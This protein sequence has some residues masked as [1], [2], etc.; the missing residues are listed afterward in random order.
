MFHTEPK[1]TENETEAGIVLQ[2]NENQELGQEG[3]V[4]KQSNGSYYICGQT[5]KAVLYGMFRFLALVRQAQLSVLP[6]TEVPHNPI[7]MLNHWDNMDGSI[8]RGYSGNSFFFQNDEMM[9]DDRTRDYARFLAS[10]GINAVAINNVNVKGAATA[11]IS[12]RFY[13]QVQE[14]SELFLSFGVKLFLS[15]NYAMPCEYGLNTADPLDATVKEWW[16]NKCKEVYQNVPDLGGFL[17]KADSEGRPGPFTYG[18]TQAD[19]A[20][21]LAEAIRPYEGLIIWRCFVYNCQQDWRDYKTDRARAGYDY[22]SELDGNFAE[23]VVLQIKNGPMDFQVREPI[24]PLFGG[25]MKTNQMLEVQIA[26]EYTGQQRHICYLI[27]W[28]KEVLAFETYLKDRAKEQGVATNGKSTVADIVSGRTLSKVNCG[29]VAVTNTGNDENWTGHDMAAANLYGFGRLAFDTKLS[30]EEIAEEWIKLTFTQA[31]KEQKVVD[32]IRQI[33]MMSWPAYEKYT[34]PLGIGWMVTP[35]CHYGPSVDGYEYSRWG[36]YHRA[37]HLGIGVDRSK[38]GTG[39]AAQYNEPNASMYEVPETCPEELLLFF[40]HMPYTYQ[41]KSGKTI[42]QHIYDTHFEGA[43]DAEKMF[44]LWTE[45]KESIDE[46]AYNRVT[47]R[48]QHQVAHSKEWR[49][50]VNSYF[51][52]KSGIKDEKGREIY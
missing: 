2:V 27:P 17:I 33:L 30:A 45:L 9:I 37:D 24:S 4:I 7:R 8:E 1:V 10:I 51:Y 25:L 52:R 50:I 38:K 15:V 42:I 29:M 14:L 21:M 22:F 6:I 32:G 28:F 41:L 20:N 12:E 48:M 26:Q 35:D 36:T 31:V 16:S 39:Y 47:E 43:K 49:D 34:S 23:N 18:R 46:E 19:G 40:H 44:A 3:Y 13:K 5:E 11:L